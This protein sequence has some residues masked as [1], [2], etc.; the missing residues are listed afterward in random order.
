MKK[1]IFIC[2]SAL[3]CCSNIQNA[4]GQKED[5]GFFNS[6]TVGVSAGTTGVGFDVA[7]PIGNYLQL[8]V[9]M[10][11]IPDISYNDELQIEAR[12]T[13]TNTVYFCDVDGSI[14]RSTTDIVLNLYP[15][16]SSSFFIAGGL[17][18]GGKEIVKVN[19]HSDDAARL[20]EQG[21][22]LGINIGDY[23]I[24]FDTK[25]N[26]S[27]G[28]MVKESR[29]YFG[30]GFGRA[31]PKKRVGFMFELGAQLHGTPEIY[32]NTGKLEILTE[33]ADNKYSDIINN[34][35]VYPVLKFRLC[36]RII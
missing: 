28:I 12:T 23:N 20:I 18:I 32:T 5:Y 30:I 9:G 11:M 15:F 25:G 33:E 26:V 24:P 1:L 34:V 17:S 7:T 2:A 29:P 3:L 16:R 27:G 31:V 10:N 6:L 13:S 35:K 22:E 4:Y 21:A 19:G 14:K 36:G 8:R